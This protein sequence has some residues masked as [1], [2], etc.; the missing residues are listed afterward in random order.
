[1]TLS[2]ECL[3]FLVRYQRLFNKKSGRWSA[4][5]KKADKQYLYIP[6]IITK[7]LKMRLDDGVG[8]NQPVVLDMNDPRRISA[9]LAPIPPPPT[10]EIVA[11]Q[12]SRFKL[13]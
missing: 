6:E 7:I 2:V 3:S 12:K 8:M 11:K 10:E 13:Q 1:M 4:N 5:P 9:V